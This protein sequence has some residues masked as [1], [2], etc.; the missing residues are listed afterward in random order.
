MDFGHKEPLFSQHSIR[1]CHLVISNIRHD[2]CLGQGP[3]KSQNPPCDFSRARGSL[4]GTEEL[5][6]VREARSLRDV[7][8][9]N[10]GGRQNSK[11]PREDPSFSQS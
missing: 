11:E 9:S 8:L 2:G 10:R 3:P 1:D 4:F 7:S 6:H 5:V